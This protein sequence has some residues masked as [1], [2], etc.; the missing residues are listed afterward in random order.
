M[1]GEEE[2]VWLGN[3]ENEEILKAKLKELESWKENR[4]YKEVEDMDQKTLFIRWV[5]SQK[6]KEGKQVW[7]ARLVV[8]LLEEEGENLFTDAPTCSGEV[9]RF[10]L[11]VME[12]MR[13]ECKTI[14]I[15]TAY[16]QG[17]QMKRR[18]W[19]RLPKEA[20]F[21]GLWELQKTV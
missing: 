18:V 14:D 4:V 6:M 16:L 8:R 3:W 11:I 7:K 12:W 20:R 15:R 17:D 2:E 21:G 19:V 1:L 13:W 9:L 5:I 10:C